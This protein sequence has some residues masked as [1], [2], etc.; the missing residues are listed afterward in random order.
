[1]CK[2]GLGKYKIAWAHR[3]NV[4]T[5]VFSEWENVLLKEIN[6]RISKLS[7]LYTNP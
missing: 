7:K 3:E 5:S 1:M 6:D 4:S 2:E